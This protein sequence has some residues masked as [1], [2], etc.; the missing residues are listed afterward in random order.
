MIEIPSIDGGTLSR[1]RKFPFPMTTN[2]GFSIFEPNRDQRNSFVNYS[3]ARYTMPSL[4]H[5]KRKLHTT[6]I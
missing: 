6:I 3:T 5:T 2:I 4:L 1:D